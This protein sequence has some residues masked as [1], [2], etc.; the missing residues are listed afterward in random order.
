VGFM[1]VAR[2]PGPGSGRGLGGAFSWGEGAAG[3]LAEAAQMTWAQAFRFHLVSWIVAVAVFDGSL[4]EVAVRVRV[5][6]AAAPLSAA[7]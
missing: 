7:T 1:D 4:S 5:A 6:A 3:R 2:P